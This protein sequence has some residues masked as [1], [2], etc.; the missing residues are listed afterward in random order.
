MYAVHFADKFA[1][2]VYY[3]TKKREKFDEY[4][5]TSLFSIKFAH[6]R[7]YNTLFINQ[8]KPIAYCISLLKLKR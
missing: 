2:S 3:F 1:V 7:L 5:Y 6:Q 4:L 8:L